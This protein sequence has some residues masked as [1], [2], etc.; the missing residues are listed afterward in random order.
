MRKL[1]SCLIIVIILTGYAAVGSAGPL[2]PG[3]LPQQET[4]P[5]VQDDDALIR[6]AV[7]TL[8]GAWQKEYSTSNHYSAGEY[9]VDIR[10]TRLIRIKEDLEEREA[11]Y[12]GDVSCI[13]EFLMYDDYYGVDGAGHG[14]GYHDVSQMLN[15]VIVHKN[16]ILEAVKASMIRQYS[17]RTYIYDYIFFI[18]EVIDCGDTYN[19]VLT[20]TVR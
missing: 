4:T 14:V 6:A 7:Q 8:K 20:F 3:M 5:A 18:K 11:K 17:A 1:V 9:M 16:G 19:Q 15:S 2:F 12:F 13:I 10:A